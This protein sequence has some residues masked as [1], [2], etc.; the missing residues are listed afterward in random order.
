MKTATLNQTRYGQLLKEIAPCVIRNDAQLE[1]FT[2][3]LLKLDERPRLSREERELAELLTILIERYE[4]QFHAVPKASPIEVLQF[5]M[6]Q[7]NLS[8]K[9]LWP[10]IGSKGIT[11]EILSGKRGISFAAATKLAE[12]FHVDPSVFVDWQ[13]ARNTRAS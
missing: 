13:T 4:E 2:S 9:D 7:R 3:A 6:E 11:S 1:Y 8:A 5:L 12:F 10:V